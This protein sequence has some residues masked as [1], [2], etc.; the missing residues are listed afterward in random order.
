MPPK[1][2]K[3]LVKGKKKGK[4]GKKKATKDTGPPPPKNYGGMRPGGIL[5]KV[6]TT[7]GKEYVVAELSVSTVLDLKARIRE[8][9]R[10]PIDAM[11]L[12][13]VDDSNEG[14][15]VSELEG[16]SES[17]KW[18]PA[19][20]ISELPDEYLLRMCGLMNGSELYLLYKNT[21][22][23]RSSSFMINPTSSS[24]SRRPSILETFRR[25]STS[26]VQSMPAQNSIA[27]GIVMEKNLELIRERKDTEIIKE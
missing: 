24:E 5:M 22:L 23:R 16:F 6:I 3:S 1:K 26:S 2:K 15:P 19:L 10:F 11:H 7:D 20:C 13:K 12:F 8:V 14:R 21:T 27:R 18:E 17:W 4:V 9:T 25:L